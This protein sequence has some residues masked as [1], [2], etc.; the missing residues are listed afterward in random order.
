M[1]SLGIIFILVTIIIP[2]PFYIELFPKVQ[3]VT[4]ISLYLGSIA[5]ILMAISQLMATRFPGVQLLFG[6]L[7]RV[8]LLHKW[9]G[10]SAV[11]AMMLH[12]IIDAEFDESGRETWLMDIAEDGGEVA[13]YGLLILG[14][15]SLITFIPYELWKKTHKFLG[16]FFAL[17]AFHY[18]FIS[19]PFALL[20][21]LGIYISA[22]CILGV[23]CYLYMLTL[24]GLIDRT[25]EYRVTDLDIHN[26]TISVTLDPVNKGIKHGA[27][28]FAFLH[29]NGEK[30]PFTIACG[31]NQKRKLKFCIKAQG[32]FS[33]SIGTGVGV[34]SEVSVS[35]AFG[36]FT[37]P[38]TKNQCW[39]AGGIGITP[40][41]AWIDAMQREQDTS[42]HLF[43]CIRSIE[44]EIPFVGQ[45]EHP[46]VI[47][48]IIDSAKGQ[49]MKVPL[50]QQSLGQNLQKVDFSFCGPKSMRQTL[51]ND[52]KIS[53]EEFEM[54]SGIKL[55]SLIA[56]LKWCFVRIPG[57][58]QA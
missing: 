38:K 37:L 46:N 28:Q 30:H 44:G 14:L 43:Y 49:R 22:F 6:G 48:H 21:P 58:R 18:I 10:I 41:L 23:V 39:I 54:R 52:I 3:V 33:K 25:C 16:A 17:G 9:V 55:N 24:H 7:D 20:D 50:L 42:V 11:S 53:F 32:D 45:L 27:G 19:K 56:I 40:F 35:R 8:Y 36:K 1:K 47:L 4:I 34:G 13:L 2:L 5:L 12:D 15:I 26:E 51:Q 57:F 31:P 29:F